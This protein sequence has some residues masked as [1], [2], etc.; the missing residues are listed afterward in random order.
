MK[1][2]K[3][4]KIDKKSTLTFKKK[5]IQKLKAYK[6]IGFWYSC[7][8]AWYKWI[9]MEGMGDFLHK[10]IHKINI[11]PGVLTNIRN[12]DKNKLLIINNLK[13]FD[14]F[15]DRYKAERR[16]RTKHRINWKAVS[17]DY[18][19]IEI[20]PYRSERSLSPLWYYG[21]D[22]ASG[23]IWNTQSIIK[24]SELIYIKRKGK[25]TAAGIRV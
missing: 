10:Y 24:T 4:N 12:K 23:C 18:G 9:L 3:R 14:T 13:D 7:Y 5:Y 22:V 6:P 1:F 16:M 21:W 8:G 2:P 25:Y 11:N 17:N 20:S 19:G 15:N